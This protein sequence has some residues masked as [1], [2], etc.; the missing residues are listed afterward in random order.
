MSFSSSFKSNLC[1]D[2]DSYMFFLSFSLH[3]LFPAP[4]GQIACL[5]E[6]SYPVQA[7]SASSMSTLK[8]V[9]QHSQ[10]KG[11][12]N[13]QNARNSQHAS[14]S[15]AT[16]SDS[17]ANLSAQLT[18]T[19]HENPLQ[20]KYSTILDALPST[21]KENGLPAE[22]RENDAGFDRCV[23]DDSESGDDDLYLSECRILLVGFEASELRK[24]VDMVRRGGG[25]RYM[26]IS[27]KLTHVVVGNPS[28]IEIKE[29][30]SLAAIGVIYLVK[31]TWLQECCCEKKEIPVLQRHIA[32]D[33]LL[34]K[35][36][37]FFNK[38]T[39]TSIDGM[40][41]GK[42]S[43]SH[44]V[45]ADVNIQENVLS[46][47]E[48]SLEAKLK[49]Q[50][51]SNNGS[52]DKKLSA[53]FK[54]KLFR[55]SSSFPESQRPEI[56]QWV[57]QGGGEMVADQNEKN[58][59]FT[60]ERHGM[61]PCQTDIMRST[62]VSSHWIHSCLEA[63]CLL[64][65]GSHILYAPLPC[66]IPLP[67]L[68]GYRLCVSRYDMKERQL[69]RNLCFVLGVKFVEKLTKKVS[70]LLCK[71]SGG[72][73]YEAACKWGIQLVTAEWIYE[74][75]IQNKVVDPI[76]FYPKE[77]S[78]QDQEAGL[79]NVSQ[80][81][82]ESFRTMSG[83]DASQ[84]P[85]QSQDVR[86]MQTVASTGF[87]ARE[88]AKYSSSNKRARLLG[89]DSIKHSLSYA[90]A[91]DNSV[92]MKNATENNLIES[93]KEL[94]SAVPDVAAAIEDL[95]EQTSKIQDHKSPEASGC[96]KNTFPSDSM[97][98]GQGPADAH[99]DLEPKHW[100]NRFDEKYDNSGGDAAAKEVYD[101]FSETQ[102]ESQVVGYE[103]D[104]SGRQMIIDRVRTRSSMA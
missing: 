77:P 25:S 71:F 66:Q 78:S 62:Y 49:V 16:V 83:N 97:R 47:S 29:V 35:D 21:T 89:N 100:I 26:S 67:G 13:S 19:D 17:E 51:G 50:N 32:Y 86:N 82:T 43:A 75:V 104:L 7:S 64:D 101:G 10:D 102:T 6:E 57:N 42:S 28:E 69:L 48:V 15:M 40:K 14:S 38:A 12:R 11:F 37:V 103:E 30:R 41:S 92:H 58:V 93:S 3:G 2:P 56:V 99:S 34:P 81:P 31:T 45:F 46:G 88:E 90:P 9:E 44:S 20:N 8:T 24:L 39:A 22:H 98:H 91:N 84:Y 61:V 53:V 79:C 76:P 59:H 27:E 23:A 80:Y 36:P 72:D 70:H 1:Y 65:V 55:F 87:V 63:G 95:L 33:L 96:D 18:E 68:E 74:C 52:D 4:S 94:S 73:K 54:R 85:S 5:N 60:V